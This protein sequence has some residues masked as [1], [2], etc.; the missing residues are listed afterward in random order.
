VLEHPEEAKYRRLRATSKVLASKVLAKKGGRE[1]LTWLGFR[2]GRDDVEAYVLLERRDDEAV[3]LEEGLRWLDDLE[4][5]RRTVSGRSV[6][7]DDP[8]NHPETTAKCE[9]AVRLPSGQRVEVAFATDETVRDVLRFAETLCGGRA[10][11]LSSPP[12]PGEPPRKFVD[13]P[14]ASSSPSSDER[15]ALAVTLE[16]AGLAPRAALIATE[17]DASAADA[18]ERAFDEARRQGLEREKRD[19]RERDDKERRLRLEKLARKRDAEQQRAD[20]LRSFDADREDKLER[21]ERDRRVLQA[22]KDRGESTRIP[23]YPEHHAS[24][25][26]KHHHHHLALAADEQEDIVRDGDDDDD[27]DDDDLGGDDCATD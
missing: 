9:L 19:K 5:G 16:E 21:V 3:R 14:H 7:G 6:A 2:S 24:A 22:K 20:A 1:V 13:E 8:Q 4:A 15:D 12:A 17:R 10:L 26:P 27:D 25:P 18:T 23:E 11:A